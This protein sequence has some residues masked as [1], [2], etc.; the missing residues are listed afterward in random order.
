MN[1]AYCRVSSKSQNLARQTKAISEWCNKNKVDINEVYSDKESGKNFE[2][3]NYQLM[4]SNL[5]QGDLIVIMSIDRLGRN[6][7]MIIREWSDITQKIGADIVVVDM[8]LLDTRQKN[9]NLTGKFIA[10]LVLQILSYVAETER[11]NIKSRQR[12]GIDLA[13]QNGVHFGRKETYDE[14]FRRRVQIDYESGMKYKDLVL[15]HG[16]SR[17]KIVVWKNQYHWVAKNNTKKVDTVQDKKTK[18]KKLAVD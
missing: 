1:Y 16:C 7:D 17:D 12:Q 13:L 5:K 2:R 10:N 15:K 9:E 14:D 3:E 18:S 11:R 4:K 8:E 6:Y